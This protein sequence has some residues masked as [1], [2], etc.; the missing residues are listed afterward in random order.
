MN[1]IRF[2]LGVFF[3]SRVNIKLAN[4]NAQW[5]DAQNYMERRCK[6]PDG[7]SRMGSI[8][9]T[10]RHRADERRQDLIDESPVKIGEK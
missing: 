8:L 1:K 9:T 5:D 6:S 7:L 2:W 4:D 10:L 3:L